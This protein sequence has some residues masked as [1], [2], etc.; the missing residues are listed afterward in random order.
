MQVSVAPTERSFAIVLPQRTDATEKSAKIDP[1]VPRGTLL[2][3]C[4]AFLIFALV[5][6]WLLGAKTLAAQL[7]GVSIIFFAI[8]FAVSTAPLRSLLRG[9]PF[10]ASIVISLATA[11]VADVC[12]VTKDFTA[13]AFQ[14]WIDP[15]IA[16]SVLIVYFGVW[17]GSYRNPVELSAAV[18]QANQFAGS[19]STVILNIAWIL[20]V[21]TAFHHLTD[22]AV[23]VWLTGATTGTLLLVG[24]I[25][26]DNSA[27]AG[28][29]GCTLNTQTRRSRPFIAILAA[30][31][32]IS[33]REYGISI[34]G[35]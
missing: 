9:V 16:A 7:S 15:L 12:M 32:G 10:W 6:P 22:D 2:I 4:V 26:L 14:G 18:H 5:R 27:V 1:R 33:A 23:A 29:L 11:N 3:A 31:A 20:A 35:E 8:A 25:V 28:G 13:Q 30:L 24:A 21:P 34:L 17:R 19:L